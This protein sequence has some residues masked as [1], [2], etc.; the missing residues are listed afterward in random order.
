LTANALLVIATAVQ[1]NG[2][3]RIAFWSIE[4]LAL[5]WCGARWRI[6]AATASG[7][8]VYTIS[9]IAILIK[10]NTYAS[11]LISNFVPIWNL[12]FLAFAVLAVSLWLGSIIIKRSGLDEA[13]DFS[14][15]FRVTSWAVALI[16]LAVEVNDSFKLLISTISN[17]THHIADILPH[18][19]FGRISVSLNYARTMAIGGIWVLYSIPL[20]LFGLKRRATL[21]SVLSLITLA[22]GAIVIAINGFDF[23]YI[24]KFIIGA[25]VRVA[26][27][28]LLFAGILVL[29]HLFS[30]HSGEHAWAS[31]A[32]NILEIAFAALILELLSLETW[33]WFERPLLTAKSTAYL[34]FSRYMV[35]SIIWSFYSIPVVLYS[36]RKRSDALLIIGLGSLAAGIAVTASQGFYFSPIRSFT[37]L[38][39]IRALAFAMCAFALI[40]QYMLFSRRVTNYVWIPTFLRILQVILSLFI[41]ELITVETIDFFNRM[42]TLA[43]QAR[44]INYSANM[45]QMILSV[46][47]LIY[48]FILISFGFWQRVRAIRFVAISL[49][50][51]AILK[52]FI[53][54][55]SFLDPLYRIF[56][57]AGLALILFATSY[58]YQRY[59]D[60]I[61]GVEQ[62]PTS[63][64][65]P[66]LPDGDT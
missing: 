16:I 31:T 18:G 60:L 51:V 27:F 42:S 48:S 41:F 12:R 3:L 15:I 44:I 29:Y 50:A 40:A 55:L 32:L 28:A 7:I 22:L 37:L 64:P 9:L 66:P 21:L 20:A 6:L 56:S 65:Q 30:R 45:R 39:N 14:G 57:F 1:F 46:V 53:S 38:F 36:L 8:I 17:S 49:F 59:R 33:T 2:F 61:L 62:S 47:W 23:Q 10:D 63:T 52:V 58:L 24:S 34:A 26:A 35:I 4:A 19:F 25:N 5:I 11:S 13:I 54:D 43:P